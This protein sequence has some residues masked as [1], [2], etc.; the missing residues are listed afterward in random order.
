VAPRVI[1]AIRHSAVVAALLSFLWPGLG[2]GWVGS[3]R[4][5]LL[6][7]APMM[8]FLGLG[9]LVLL[10]QGKAR[11]LGLL[12]QPSV[13]LVLLTVMALAFY[14]VDDHSFIALGQTAEALV[15]GWIVVG[16]ARGFRGVGRALELRPIAY[17][18]KI[19]YGIYIFHYL[20]P[21][22]LA[23]LAQHLGGSYPDGGF[24]SFALSSAVTVA[25]AAASWQFFESP[26]NRLKRFFP[27]RTTR[28][29]SEGIDL[30]IADVGP[31]QP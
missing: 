18:G 12:L 21:V 30:A 13:L 3:R 9:V 6:F 8:L 7:A 5:A 15:C 26:L 25:L 28:V 22:V 31:A 10:V 11:T 24:R 23:R 20:V 19:S 2:Q 16:A 1:A 4:R 27:Y 17:L 14:G 29:R